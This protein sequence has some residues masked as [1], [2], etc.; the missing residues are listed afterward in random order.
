M[1]A[2]DNIVQRHMTAMHEALAEYLA[3]ERKNTRREDDADDFEYE[4]RWSVAEA[5]LPKG[6]YA[7]WWKDEVIR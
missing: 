5:L 7:E 4:V 6:D 3:E 2:V 1:S